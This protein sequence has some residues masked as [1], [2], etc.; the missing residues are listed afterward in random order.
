[1]VEERIRQI[2]AEMEQLR[3]EK[4]HAEARALGERTARELKPTGRS[5]E[6]LDVAMALATYKDPA[7][8]RRPAL[9]QALARLEPHLASSGDPETL[10]VAGA[11]E[12]RLWELSARLE[13]LER[14]LGHYR[15][16]HALDVQ[17]AW[18]R[19]GFPGINAAYLLEVLANFEKQSAVPELV[20][21]SNPHRDEARALRRQLIHVPPPAKA[22][23]QY[24]HRVTLA[25]AHLGLG[26][27][28]E[29]T[30]RLKE[31][32][33]L[34]PPSW[35]LETTALQLAGLLR[36][37]HNG[38]IPEE[39]KRVLAVLVGTSAEAVC[40]AIRGK[41]GL[42]LSGGGFR[43]SFFHIGVLAALAERDLLRHVEVIS[44][45]SGGSLLGAL[46]YLELQ[47][48]LRSKSDADISRE[49]NAY[50]ALVERLAQRFAEAVR[51]DMRN[52]VGTSFLDNLAMLS[53]AGSRTER[54]AAL[55]ERFLYDRVGPEGDPAPHTGPRYV[56]ELRIQPA[57]EPEGF[58]PAHGNW[59]RANKV[60]VIVFNA[61]TL[62]T[63]HLWE[64]TATD[65]GEPDARAED[66]DVNDR[67]ESRPYSA[68]PA[69]HDKVRLGHAVAASACVP[70]LFDPLE[71]R[72]AYDGHTVQLVDGG[73]HDNQG[74]AALI[75]RDCASI[76]VSDASGQ[77]SME[78]HPGDSAIAVALRS[79]TV[80][81]ARLREAQFQDLQS[82]AVGNLLRTVRFLHLKQ[83]FVPGVVKVGRQAAAAEA[84]R[85]P[86]SYGVSRDVQTR[87]AAL[88]TDLDAFSELEAEMLMTSGYLMASKYVEPE[89][90]EAP[91]PAA[92]APP[93]SFLR[94]RPFMQA[95]GG[96][97]AVQR[98]VLDL[99]TAGEQTVGK[100]F[101]VSH[102]ARAAAWG[103]GL[104]GVLGLV[105]LIWKYRSSPITTLTVGAVALAAGTAILEWRVP[106]LRELFQM[107]SPAR[108]IVR[109]VR[110]AALAA[111]VTAAAGLAV[112]L[113][114]RIFLA[115]GE[116]RPLLD[117]HERPE[118]TSPPRTRAM[119]AS[120]APETKPAQE[121]SAG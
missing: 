46:Y 64:F 1:M 92:G 32:A 45:V 48:L 12:K 95:T 118:T 81:Q 91:V 42:A 69:P 101:L 72:G 117:E 100:P 97:T 15:R 83:G 112:H 70:G 47:H 39:G 121:L 5:L 82:R 31:A 66:V 19:Q 50:P 111:V 28:P 40:S 68:F 85:Q 26:Q 20:A 73:L 110:G 78:S 96:G 79:N 34:K 22:D 43:A 90:F 76:I 4:K 56:R 103:V 11:I 62:N 53:G 104:G 10:G 33:A 35:Q 119:P 98:K 52:R 102:I 3:G 88:R 17:Q 58:N 99:L 61:A 59:A 16:G 63:G 51:L 23:E 94:V 87:L 24:F 14:A 75:R 57:G 77:M 9:R 74:T 89:A 29:A 86:L 71:L 108:Q 13:H 54:I 30:S 107:L 27:F 7:L 37:L 109:K 44:C 93:P 114:R 6:L 18:P 67:F 106:R 2:A 21:R 115:A 41:L 105:L 38:T 113:G 60:P 25:E 49:A 120:A 36:L 80:L 116:V 84:V 8:P 65:M 55:Y